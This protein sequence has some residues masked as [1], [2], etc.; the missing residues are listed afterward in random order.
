[1]D[2]AIQLLLPI[3]GGLMLGY[4]LTQSFG[5]S[6]IWMVLLAILGMVGGIGILYKRFSYPELYQKGGAL[7]K[8]SH[9]HKNKPANVQSSSDLEHSTSSTS[10]SAKQTLSLDELHF[11]YRDEEELPSEEA[12]DKFTQKPSKKVE[13]E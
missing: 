6:P 4:W 12:V 7:S 10:P 3:L 2:Y 1:M 8:T 5:A 13:D 9:T 11:L